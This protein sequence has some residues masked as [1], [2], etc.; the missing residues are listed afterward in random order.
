MFHEYGHF[1]G[2]GYEK[3]NLWWNGFFVSDIDKFWLVIGKIFFDME[4]FVGHEILVGIK[5]WD[6]VKNFVRHGIFFFEVSI[7]E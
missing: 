3:K 7:L 4:F 2:H 5:F 6:M 1:Y